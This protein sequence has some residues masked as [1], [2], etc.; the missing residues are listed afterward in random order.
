VRRSLLFGKGKVA[1][2]STDHHYR[3]RAAIVIGA[4]AMALLLTGCGGSP[5]TLDADGPK[6]SHIATLWWV[7]F[8]ISVI[9]C[10]I[11][12]G[13]LM[14][15]VFRRRPEAPSG[16]EDKTDGTTL[17]LVGGAIVPGVILLAVF[18]FVL[19]VMQVTASPLRP[20]ALTIEVIGHRW[21]FEI[22]YPDSHIVT[23]NEMHV[24]VGQPVTL[25]LTS[26]DVIHS[27]WVPQIQQKTDM[28]PGRINTTWFE[29]SK[30]G[31]YTGECAEFCGIEHA[32]MDFQVIAEPPARF[33]QW[34]AQQEKP[35]PQPRTA[36]QLQGEQVFLGSACVYCHTIMGTNA[37]GRIGPDLTHL[38]GRQMIGAGLLP[39]TIGNLAGWIADSQTIKPGNAMP[40]MALDSKD[41]QAILAYLESLK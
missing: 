39:N 26:A 4:S 23:A 36:L 11:V 25:E 15:A 28:I 12:F 32:E 21:W 41:M 40:P 5:S 38:A 1:A 17:V 22:H 16:Q 29:V 6:G 20:A 30:A 2:H 14:Y 3:R 37:S 18:G 7:M 34:L 13:M 24:P 35:A 9:V 19:Y 10:V 8:A 27:F 33:R 31:T